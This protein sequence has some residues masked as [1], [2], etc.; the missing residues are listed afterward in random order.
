MSTIGAMSFGMFAMF[1][2]DFCGKKSDIADV[3]QYYDLKSHCL[4][5]W[6][7]KV[8]KHVKCE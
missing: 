3:V 8:S 1:A 6:I 4:T 2:L 7:G 5:I